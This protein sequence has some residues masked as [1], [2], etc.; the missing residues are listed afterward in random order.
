MPEPHRTCALSA[1][2]CKQALAQIADGQ[3]ARIERLQ[4]LCAINSGSWHTA[5]LARMRDAL[6][7]LFAP[8]ADSVE[9][10]ALAPVQQLTRSGERQARALGELIVLRKRVEAPI[11]VLLVG[12]YDTVFGAE[13]A[14]QNGRLLDA[15]TLN[16]PGA[17]DLKGGLLVLQAALAAF[18][19]L[20]TDPASGGLPGR[21]QLGWT[22][23]L[24]PDEEIGSPGSAAAL[25][26]FA[27]LTDVGFCYEPS[28][29]SGELAG[30]R[31]GSGTFT[32]HVRGRAAHAGREHHLGRNAIVAMAGIV[33]RLEALNGRHGDLTVN[34]GLIDGGGAV[35]VVP[36]SCL[37]KVNA[38]VSD[39]A[40]AQIFEAELRAAA[41]EV[42]ARDGYTVSIDGSF[43]RPAKP[44]TP[45]FHTLLEAVARCGQQLGLTLR[46]NATGGCCDGNNLAAAGLANVDTLGVRG[47]N[48]HSAEEFC[49]LDSMTERAQLSLL[50]LAGLASGEIALPAGEAQS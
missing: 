32:V 35:N 9:V 24:N 30:A 39:H 4:A 13:H 20:S 46:W 17:A 27:A 1:P 16:A 14:F 3:A 48:I 41:A 28:L 45:A 26:E 18:E 5:G 23:L 8:L 31:K 43:H 37:M 49:L 12:H 7:P 15:N 11:Q 40:Q 6:L 19:N 33:A 42:S 29:P 25:A 34:V 50:L 44:M 10:R 47:G 22:V 36:D 21:D 38:R 2:A